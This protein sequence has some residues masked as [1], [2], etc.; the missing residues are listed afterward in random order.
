MSG[1]SA[2]SPSFDVPC[3]VG[4]K[5]LLKL[6]A[7]GGMGDVYLAATTGL[8]GAERPC[9]VKTVRRDHIH[10]GSFLARFLDEARVQAQL[11]HPGVAQVIEASTDDRGEPYTVVEYVEGRSLAEVRQRATQVGHTLTWADAVAISIE[12]AQ[13]LGHVHSRAGSDG[14]PLGIVHRDLSPQNVMIGYAGDVKLIDFGTAR[15]QNRRCHTVAGVVFAKPGYVAPEIARHEVGDGRIDVYALG[16][17]LWELCKGTRLLTGDSQKH[18]EEVARGRFTIPDIAKQVGAPKELDAVMAKLIANAP[19]NRFESATIAAQELAKLLSF[20][21]AT[22][23]GERSVRAR[24]AE[25]MTAIYPQEPSRSR[26][27][28]GK[29]LEA[30]KEI[31]PEQHTPPASGVIERAEKLMAEDPSLLSGTPYRLIR[32]IGEGASG[33]VWEAHHVELDR[34]LAV[35]VMDSAHGSALDS[36]DRFRKEA[37]AVANLR[38][39]NLAFLH[40]FGKSLDGRIFLAMEYL[41]GETLA[42]RLERHE[43]GLDPMSWREAAGFAIEATHALEA[44]HDAGLVHRDLKPENLFVTDENVLKLLDFGVAIAKSDAKTDEKKQRG[45]AIFGTPE[46]MAPE[47]VAGE[48][49][50]ARCDLYALGCV[51]YELTTGKRPF[52]GNSAVEVM[53]KQLR[54]APEAPTKCAPTRGIPEALETVILKAM[55]KKPEDRYASAVEFRAAISEVVTGAKKRKERTRK[56]LTAAFSAALAATAFVGYSYRESLSR[57]SLPSFGP[58]ASASINVEDL[59]RVA[60]TSAATASTAAQPSEAARVVPAVAETNPSSMAPATKAPSDVRQA[61]ESNGSLDRAREFA[62][63]RP[64]DAKA[65]RGWAR[66]ALHVK[67][68]QEAQ[69]AS[70]AWMQVD[71][72]SEPRVILA[73]ALDGLGRKSEARTLLETYLKVHPHSEDTRITLARLDNR[74]AAAAIA[75]ATKPSSTRQETPRLERARITRPVSTSPVAPNSSDEFDLTP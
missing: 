44:A 33:T 25:L 51:L 65:Q 57:M 14:M 15:G 30:A 55:S 73:Q 74:P 31:M 18:L 62:K 10:D 54:D 5:L 21:P 12:M 34:K 1:F 75:Q 39:P 36:I 28:F 3:L 71:P 52:S 4:R 8:E 61:P 6:I 7:R 53:G 66:I 29:L 56:Q 17:M 35:K 41:E 2:E 37:R 63:A 43:L 69:I 68:Y 60:D 48:P 23:G 16:V 40:D 9:V 49:V 45:F 67:N 72:S 22:K 59:P 19:D 26:A 58:S 38:H 24:I 47:Q 50:D 27:E 46:Y 64:R 32:K 11:N 20:A 13:A 42:R 70:E